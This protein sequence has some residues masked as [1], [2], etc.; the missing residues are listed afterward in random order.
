MIARVRSYIRCGRL[1]LAALAAPLVAGAQP[2]SDVHAEGARTT[3]AE[4]PS[5]PRAALESFLRLA[6]AGRYDVAGRW[7]DTG[8]ITTADASDLA[9]RLYAVLARSLTVDLEAV[10]EA[11]VGDTADGLP[12]GVEQLGAIVDS[13]GERVPVRMVRVATTGDQ[14]WQFSQATV[15]CIPAWYAVLPD[16]W[17][18]E[19][20]PRVLLKAGPLGL[21]WWQWLVLPVLLGLACLIG[22]L[23]GRAVL[24]SV[25]RLV[26]HTATSW[27]DVVLERMGA[28]LTAALTLGA[29][30]AGA[31]FLSLHPSAAQGTRHA[32]RVGYF[33]LMFWALWR[34]VDVGRQVLSR[35]GW[36]QTTASSRA[37]LPL[38]GR[39][40]KIGVLAIGAVAVLS[41]LG[42]PVASL[43]AGL[44]LGGLALALAAQKTVEN[45]FGA[46][47]I[48]IDQPFREGDFVK[49][50]DFVGT[51]EAIGLRSTRFRT[52]DRTIITIP[53]GKLADMRLESFTVRDRIR[54]AMTI[55]LVYDTTSTQMRQVLEHVERTLRLHPK[56]W[57]DTVVV[58]FGAL[59]ASSLDIEV[60]AWFE[61]SDWG[62]FQLI[63]QDILLDVMRIV[64][65]AGSAFAFPTRTIHVAAEQDLSRLASPRESVAEAC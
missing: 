54:L 18:L 56:I 46:F 49:I 21:L 8:D 23:L 64:E 3:S 63:R 15:Q 60:M 50:E 28:P 30:A 32:I 44:G 27:D 62:E 33:A 42:Y 13:S 52:L 17:A 57:P 53:N 65:Q 6:R 19:H 51:V 29:V 38:G 45:L 20:F 58:R 11:A 1:L 39:I 61:T 25:A 41:M 26:T 34:L 22:W 48:G 12:P 59:G 16:R 4:S 55:G 10:S 2:P 36:A 35:S 14:V 5:S 24:A 7:L 40:A 43:L 9:R 47:S 37:L 31:H